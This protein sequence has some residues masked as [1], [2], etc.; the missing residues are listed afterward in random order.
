MNFLK[1]L[2][3]AIKNGLIILFFFFFY[4]QYIFLKRKITEEQVNNLVR[5]ALRV[6]FMVIYLLFF[7]Y[8]LI[9]YQYIY[10]NVDLIIQLREILLLLIRLFIQKNIDKFLWKQHAKT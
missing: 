10:G 8:L 6:K 2:R 9:F 1:P 5:D 7:I 4:F 3:S